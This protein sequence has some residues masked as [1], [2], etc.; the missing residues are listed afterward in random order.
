LLARLHERGVYFRAAHFG[1]ILVTQTDQLALIDI[2]EASFFRGML[3][4]SL[5]ARNFR[6]LISYPEDAAVLREFG[7]QRLLQHYLNASGLDADNQKRFL[8][9]VSRIDPMFR[10]SGDAPASVGAATRGR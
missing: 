3:S 4:P 6:P 5:R 9:T 10:W 8:E 1:N 7:I 2:S